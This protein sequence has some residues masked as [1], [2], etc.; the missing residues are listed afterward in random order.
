MIDEN[1]IRNL[2][3]RHTC[4]HK[5]VRYRVAL[6]RVRFDR[7]S[8]V[9]IEPTAVDLDFA[10]TPSECGSVIPVELHL[11]LGV[12]NAADDAFLLEAIDGTIRMIVDGDLPPGTRDLL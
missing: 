3:G 8:A 4:E 5:G 6:S 11:R 12:E 1:H 9:G 10:A 2:V 7:L